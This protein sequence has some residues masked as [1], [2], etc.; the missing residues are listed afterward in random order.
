MRFLLYKDYGSGL[1]NN[2]MSVEIAAGL[3]FLTGRQ[4]VHYG[5]AG[6]ERAPLHVRGGAYLRARPAFAGVVDNSQHPTVFELMEPLPLDRLTWADFANVRG[7]LEALDSDVRLPLAVFVHGA[8]SAQQAAA[9]HG[10][11]LRAF[12]AGRQV[13]TDPPEPVWH[14]H[15]SNLAFASRFFFDPPA[16]LHELLAGI[17]PRREYLEL[18][19]RVAAALGTFNGVHIRLTDFRSFMPQ[20]EDYAESITA[21]ITR[22]MPRE[23][24]LV[25]C[26]DESHERAFFAPILAAF[27]RHVFL[28]EF[29]VREFPSEFRALPYDDEQSLGYVCNLVMRQAQEFAGTPG[30]T[31]SGVIHREWY[32][33]RVSEDATRPWRFRFIGSGECGAPAHQP[34]YF[35]EGAFVESLPGPY[36]WNRTPMRLGTDA[37]SWYREWP[38]AVPSRAK[39]GPAAHESCRVQVFFDWNVIP[40]HD[41]SKAV[42]VV[43]FAFFSH[44]GEEIF[45]P[46]IHD[47]EVIGRRRNWISLETTKWILERTRH[48]IWWVKYTDGT[49]G[50]RLEYL[51]ERNGTKL[52]MSP[53]ARVQA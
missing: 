39:P 42:S 15:N 43:V 24:L 1:F 8:Q 32:R 50:P 49:F 11:R 48:C 12:A 41:A 34:G 6:P 46:D 38:E 31:Y 7:Q 5:S 19:E 16:G 23:Q 51:L 10:A 52:F 33:R 53:A 17:R 13:L 2:W 29:V 25:I 14:L 27:P 37:L 3:A 22:F 44:E 28:D 21:T 20:A 47:T 35:E 4:W 45:R 18:A 40:A 9:T 30:S 36:S 26:S